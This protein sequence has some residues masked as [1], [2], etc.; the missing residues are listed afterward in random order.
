MA[1][2]PEGEGDGEKRGR[3]VGDRGDPVCT[4]VV[5]G[6]SAYVV[7]C[8][9]LRISVLEVVW[10]EGRVCQN[11]ANNGLCCGV[12]MRG[13]SIRWFLGTSSVCVAVATWGC[14]PCAYLGLHRLFLTIVVRHIDTW[15]SSGMKIRRMEEVNQM[16]FRKEGRAVDVGQTKVQHPDRVLWYCAL[17]EEWT[18]QVPQV[19]TV[20]Q[21]MV[22]AWVGPYVSVAG[23]RH[24]GPTQAWASTVEEALERLCTWI[25]EDRQADIRSMR[26]VV[27]GRVQGEEWES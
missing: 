18:A 10:E 1:C 13:G 5:C 25:Y 3:V 8:G 23:V 26:P 11:S 15:R 19:V 2:L 27:A 22:A 20:K 17:I 6:C 4:M 24:H 14:V 12:L 7:A 16:G 9:V 21:E